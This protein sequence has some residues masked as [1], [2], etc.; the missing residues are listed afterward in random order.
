MIARLIRCDLK[1]RIALRRISETTKASGSQAGV[2]NTRERRWFHWAVENVEMKKVLA[3]HA[4][5]H[6]SQKR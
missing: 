1:N 4:G 3:K 2:W 6:T 5:E